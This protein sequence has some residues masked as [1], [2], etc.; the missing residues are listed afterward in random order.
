MPV[1]L[2]P[3]SVVRPSTYVLGL[4]DQ[5]SAVPVLVYELAVPQLEKVDSQ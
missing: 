2:S 4:A 1:Q 3:W 5:A